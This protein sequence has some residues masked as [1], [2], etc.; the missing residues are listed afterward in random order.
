MELEVMEVMEEVMFEVMEAKAVEDMMF[1]LFPTTREAG[2]AEDEDD[3]Y[4]LH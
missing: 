4:D 1:E 3:Q 2:D